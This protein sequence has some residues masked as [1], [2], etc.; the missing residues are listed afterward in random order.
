VYDRGVALGEQHQRQREAADGQGPLI[1]HR[2]HL[3]SLLPPLS[4]T[5][6]CVETQRSEIEQL[7]YMASHTAPELQG[8]LQTMRD[9]TT[10]FREKLLQQQARIQQLYGDCADPAALTAY[11][12]TLQA[13][14]NFHFR[15][16][17]AF[18]WVKKPSPTDHPVWDI[19]M[20]D[21]TWIQ[22]EDRLPENFD[23]K[24]HWSPPAN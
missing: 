3:T 13:P 18:V 24:G 9:A 2:Q 12:F 11:L 21:G 7:L 14:T 6:N 5:Y 16:K 20:P 8:P 10:D 19:Y 17:I 4:R 22:P 15:E 23:A 1:E